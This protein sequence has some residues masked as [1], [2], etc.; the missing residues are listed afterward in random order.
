MILTEL[1]KM[2]NLVGVI[3]IHCSLVVV[4][5]KL[6]NMDIIVGVEKIASIHVSQQDINTLL[7]NSSF[8]EADGETYLRNPEKHNAWQHKAVIDYVNDGGENT[9]ASY[10]DSW[11]LN[12]KS[13]TIIY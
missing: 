4:P 2:L 9:Y 6:Y 13:I 7:A 12:K 8:I 1:K 10:G 11:I 3:D 5:K